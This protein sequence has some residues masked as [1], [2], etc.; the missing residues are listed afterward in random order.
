LKKKIEFASGPG[1]FDIGG[2]A[3][4]SLEIERKASGSVQLIIMQG[5]VPHKEFGAS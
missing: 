5:R 2:L 3:H 4:T 1:A